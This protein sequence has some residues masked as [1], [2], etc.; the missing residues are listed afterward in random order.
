RLGVMTAELTKLGASIKETEDGFVIEGA[1]ALTGA[2]VDGHDDHRLSMS[3]VVAGLAASGDTT[4]LDARCASD[5]FPGYAETM[6]SLG[7]DV[8]VKDLRVAL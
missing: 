7:A 4:V 5:S 1:Q 3:L 2:T 6:A 8:S